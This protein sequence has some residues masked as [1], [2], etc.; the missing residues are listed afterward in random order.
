MYYLVHIQQFLIQA[1]SAF[2][3]NGRDFQTRLQDTE[4]VTSNIRGFTG[5]RQGT[6]ILPA[7]LNTTNTILDGIVDLLEESLSTTEDITD[8]VPI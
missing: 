6:S 3:A 8:R 4:L 5:P 1:E 7:D 2:A